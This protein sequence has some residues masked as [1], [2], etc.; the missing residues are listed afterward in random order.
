MIVDSLSN[1]F[2][3]IAAKEPNGIVGMPSYWI[4]AGTWCHRKLNGFAQLRSVVLSQR[5][6]T[7]DW[8]L[9][10]FLL[11]EKIYINW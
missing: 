5:R 10:L 6:K 4:K 9:Y 11:F 2:I 1:V 3:L 7:S 8:K